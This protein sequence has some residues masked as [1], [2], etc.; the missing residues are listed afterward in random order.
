MTSMGF[1][2]SDKARIK[3]YVFLL[4]LFFSVLYP[5]GVVLSV[6][7]INSYDHLGRLTQVEASDGSMSIL[8]TYDAVGNRL[9]M[10]VQSSAGTPEVIDEGSYSLDN[11]SVVINISK[12]GNE[13]GDLEYEY[14]IGT[15]E[16]GTEVI[17]WTGLEIGPDGNGILTGLNLP[18]DQTYYI[19]VRIKN[20]AGEVVGGI[21]ITDGIAILDP[22]G[23]FDG[24]GYT[25]FEEDEAGTDPLD[26]DSNLD[27]PVVVSTTPADSASDIDRSANIDITFSKPMD[28]GMLASGYLSVFGTI[29]GDYTGYVTLDQ[30]S[31]ICTFDPDTEFVLEENVSVLIFGDVSNIWGITLDGNGNGISD[32]SPL[33]DFGWSFTVEDSDGY[34]VQVT[35]LD[36]TSCPLIVARVLVTDESGQAVTDLGSDKFTLYEDNLLQSDFDVSLMNEDAS[37]ISVCLAL[38]YS[39][40][41]P[42]EAITD[43]ENAAAQF[44]TNMSDNDAG[45]IIKFAYGTEVSQAFT[46]DKNALI[47]AISASTSLNRGSTYLYDA[48]Y[49]GVTDTAAQS[50]NLAVIAMTDGGDSGSSHSEDQAIAHAQA[51]GV[52]VYTIGLGSSI[53]A[54]V[55]QRIAEE[56]GGLYFVAPTSSELAEIYDTIAGILKNQYILTFKTRNWDSLEHSLQIIAS[57]NALAGSDTVTFMSCEPPPCTADYDVDGD[58]DG[59]DL[60]DFADGYSVG[61]PSADLNVDTYIDS[62]D[63]GVI[64]EELG[65]TDCPF[66]E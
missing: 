48:I 4:S 41:M 11:S 53:N 7:Y 8:Y 1:C 26:P 45:E 18:Q 35:E 46:T 56:T 57:R 9:S 47:N 30:E 63:V 40:S 16:G 61:D 5:S 62:L 2:F 64:G 50:G 12:L 20:F 31:K 39:G 28:D 51:S 43:M 32:G 15:T 6:E 38:D 65:R 19:S 24:D 33:D 17:N 3:E 44:V 14:A 34:T 42:S 54:S 22:A 66:P 37:P 55:L 13:Y 27:P 60:A 29:G 10:T 58:M 21:G 52:P 23:D 25:S 36:D 49:D 59:L